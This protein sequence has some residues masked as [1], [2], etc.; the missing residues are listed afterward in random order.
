MGIKISNIIIKTKLI[1]QFCLSE[2][3]CCF[4]YVAQ[5]QTPPKQKTKACQPDKPLPNEKWS[6]G[7]CPKPKKT[8]KEAVE[9]RPSPVQMKNGDVEVRPKHEKVK[10][11]GVDVCPNL[12][13]LKSGDVHIRPFP[14]KIISSTD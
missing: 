13:R 5:S 12:V 2:G 6:F 4:I 11:Q 7:S 9:I 14:K 8:I 10:R 3:Y 1:L